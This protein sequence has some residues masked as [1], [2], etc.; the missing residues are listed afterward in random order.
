MGTHG[1]IQ[2]KVIVFL[3]LLLTILYFIDQISVVES[4]EVKMPLL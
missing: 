3:K 4:I 2:M 1:N